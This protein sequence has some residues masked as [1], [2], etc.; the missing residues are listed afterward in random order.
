[1]VGIKDYVLYRR[2][3]VG[4]RGGGVAIYARTQ[5]QSSDWQF[6]ADDRTYE[7]H[8]IRIGDVFVAA[9]YH[10]PKP[11]YSAQALLSFRQKTPAQHAL[12]LQHVSNITFNNPFPTVSSVPSVNTQ[13]EFD[14]FYTASLDLLN[15]FYP[16]RTITVTSRDPEYVTAEIKSKL[17]RKNRLMRAGRVE[18]AG[19]LSVRIRKEMM[20]N[21]RMR[22]CKIGGRADAK[23]MWE[24]VRR[25]TG[26]Q[27]SVTF[28]PVSSCKPKNA[29]CESETASCELKNAS[30]E[31]ENA[32]C[33]LIITS[34]ESKSASCKSESA[35]C[36]S[37]N[38][39]CE[40]K[41]AS[42]ES[43]NASCKSESASCESETASCE[44]KNASCES[45]NASC[46]SKS[47]RLRVASQNGYKVLLMIN[48]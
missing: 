26:R 5:L 7:L 6:S 47:A 3:R 22:L 32:S 10:P 45:E 4:R 41:N 38:A 20:R 48:I 30:C 19:A 25:L 24:A 9:L 16:Q 31:S 8:W 21:S 1:M 14:Y 27:Q 11:L 2:D 40:L 17:R 42:C 46:E 23:D 18:E 29:S 43:E 39:S 12:F 36:E 44:L 35:S 34:C 28:S 15:Q 37:E 33:E 13:A